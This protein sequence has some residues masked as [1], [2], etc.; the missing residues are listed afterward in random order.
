MKRLLL[1]LPYYLLL[2]ALLLLSMPLFLWKTYK[3]KGFGTG[4]RERFGLYRIPRSSEPQ[5]GLYVH[6]VS[7]GEAMIALKFIRAWQSSNDEPV[8]LAV[9]TPTGH[10]VARAA[11]L[12]G[13]RVIYSPLDLPLVVESCLNRFAPRCIALIEA[14]L[15]PHF[16]ECCH[17]RGIP[18][19]MLNARLSSRSEG[20][21]KKLTAVTSLLFARL[22]A[23][24]VQN[25]ADA[26]RFK[27][28]GVSADIIHVVGSI[29]F[30]LIGDAQRGARD[31][32]RTLLHGMSGEKAIVLASSTHAGEEALIARAARDAGAFPLII[33]RHEERRDEVRRDME[34][35]GFTPLLRS[36]HRDTQAQPEH[37]AQYDCYIADT[38]GEM[39]DWTQL[40]DIVVI[41]KSFL[42]KGGQNP[43]EAIAAGVA[44]IAG[45]HMGNFSD[46]ITLLEEA[47]GIATTSSEEI[48]EQIKQLL[49]DPVHRQ[50]Q[51]ERAIHAL[52]YHAGATQRSVTL[53]QTYYKR[54]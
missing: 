52:Q 33:P 51:C 1:L 12:Q 7:V 6:A 40:A 17:R 49:A 42:S 48:G 23:L 11:G 2:P 19:I 38:T 3:R 41:G 29:K 37:L 10:Q 39:R 26:E 31:D 43:A 45:P 50:S 20:R 53:V 28:I 30:D 25:D 21:Y 15:W 16:A 46:L 13:V 36:S 35:L 14:E 47:Q 5:H 8:V 22:N 27:G 54:S 4:I 9:S 34:E 18:L 32:F 44:V 24:A